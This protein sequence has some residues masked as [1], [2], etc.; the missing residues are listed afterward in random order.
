MMFCANFQ[1]EL[2]RWKDI[3]LAVPVGWFFLGVLMISTF[4]SLVVAA[5]ALVLIGVNGVKLARL[6]NS[7]VCCVRE[8]LHTMK[9]TGRDPG[10][11]SISSEV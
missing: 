8:R 9:K 7:M 3:P 5:I 10:A 1:T 4:N 6:A 2:K 11:C